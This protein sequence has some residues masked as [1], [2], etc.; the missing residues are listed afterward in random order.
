MVKNRIIKTFFWT[1]VEIWSRF[2]RLV[3]FNCVRKEVFTSFI[4]EKNLW[5]NDK[6]RCT[7]VWK[8]YLCE[9]KTTKYTVYKKE[10]KDQGHLFNVFC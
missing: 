8:E 5:T 6:I 10:M 9:V 2:F 7:Y 4:L 1:S 3:C